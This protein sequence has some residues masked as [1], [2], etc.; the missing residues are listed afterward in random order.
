MKTQFKFLALM[1]I[2]S[3][4]S[5]GQKHQILKES[6]AVD[7]NS[8]ILL[9]FENV[10][11]AIEESTDGKIHF[12]YKLEFEGYSKNQIKE[13]IEGLKAEVTH[14]DN[15]VTL[16]VKS[17]NQITFRTFALT[18]DHGLYILSLIHI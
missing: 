2:T 7:K 1:L 9:N 3:V 10:Y 6:I 17:L 4:L 5:Y 8:S 16:D 13:K 14:A 18:S 15:R 11:V 12:D